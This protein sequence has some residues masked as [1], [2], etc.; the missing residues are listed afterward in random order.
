MVIKDILLPLVG[1]PGAAAIA[2]IKNARRSPGLSVPGLPQW[3]LNRIFW[4]GRR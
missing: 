1:E 2:A 3:P 4:S